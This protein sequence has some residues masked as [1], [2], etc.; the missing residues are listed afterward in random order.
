MKTKLRFFL[1]PL[2][3]WAAFF[4]LPVMQTGCSSPSTRVAQVQTLKAVGHTAEA[5]VATSAQLYGA[6]LITDKQAR[7]VMDLF[8]G[9]FQPAYRVA[10][11]AVNANL[12]SIASP[13]LVSLAAQLATIVASYQKP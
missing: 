5:A 11:N 4:S 3:V 2:L 12:D 6:H 1:L 10:V 8:D 7:D 9:K 13:E